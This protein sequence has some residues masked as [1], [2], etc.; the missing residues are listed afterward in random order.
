MCRFSGADL[1]NKFVFVQD[2]G[3]TIYTDFKLEQ[4]YTPD[5]IIAKLRSLKGVLEPNLSSENQKILKK[6]GFKKI[7][8]IFNYIP[9]EGIMTI[10]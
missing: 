5:E 3:S 6:A 4:G 2:I 7:I 10:K 8:T 9:F 1:F